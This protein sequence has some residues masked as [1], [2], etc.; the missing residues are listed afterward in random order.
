MKYLHLFQKCLSYFE[1]ISWFKGEPC[2]R[3]QV[4]CVLE[5]VFFFLS[6]TGSFF[7]VSQTLLMLI[8]VTMWRIKEI[9][10]DRTLKKRKERNLSCKEHL[11]LFILLGV[12]IYPLLKIISYIELD[13]FLLLSLSLFIWGQS[14]CPKPKTHEL[15]CNLAERTEVEALDF[16]LISS[17][18]P[19]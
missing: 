2:A 7:L 12:G 9:K 10:K 14:N 1:D 8:I 4:S 6:K 16:S 15:N 3:S 17:S 18:S 13:N 19:Q 5:Q 11:E